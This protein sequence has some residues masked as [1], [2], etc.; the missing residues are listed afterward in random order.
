MNIRMPIYRHEYRAST[1]FIQDPSLRRSFYVVG[2]EEPNRESGKEPREVSFPMHGTES[3]TLVPFFAEE[4][5][6]FVAPVIAWRF[7]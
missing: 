6:K 4:T 1:N 3:Y 2:L 7:G 5:R